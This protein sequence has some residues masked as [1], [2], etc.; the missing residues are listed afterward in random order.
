MYP[1]VALVDESFT[2]SYLKLRV[3]GFSK[4]IIKSYK[5]NKTIKTNIF[6]CCVN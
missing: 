3:G 1:N 6:L 2:I 5:K 4:K